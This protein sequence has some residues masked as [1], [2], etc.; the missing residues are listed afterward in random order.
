[1]GP[2]G[3]PLGVDGG[4]LE[5]TLG[6]QAAL[7]NH[8]FYCINGYILAFER[9]LGGP[10]GG[11]VEA[12]TGGEE[13]SGNRG[14]HQKNK[15]KTSEADEEK[16]GSQRSPRGSTLIDPGPPLGR[17]VRFTIIRPMFLLASLG[18]SKVLLGASGGALG[19]PRLPRGA[20]G[21]SPGGLG[22]VLGGPLG[23]LGAALGGRGPPS[24]STLG[25]Q[26]ALQNHWF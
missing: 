7:Q 3:G 1:M 13:L 25:K 4:P 14:A 16:K 2:L 26:A 5:T 9:G 8:W 12:K 19:G 20:P 17:S 24:E 21:G 23:S 15:N 18:R 6:K 11:E 10:W 22:A